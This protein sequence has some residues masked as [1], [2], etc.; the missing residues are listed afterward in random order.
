[1]KN[2]TKTV[3][4]QLDWICA[5]MLHSSFGTLDIR[6]SFIWLI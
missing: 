6:L 4:R 5:F 1:M 2:C 3:E